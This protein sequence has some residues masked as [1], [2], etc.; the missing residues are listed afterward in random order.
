[1]ISGLKTV[2][3]YK[4]FCYWSLVNSVGSHTYSSHWSILN[5]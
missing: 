3:F 5:L 4:K 1:V 2:R